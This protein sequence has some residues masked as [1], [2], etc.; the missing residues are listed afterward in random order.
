[1]NEFKIH[2]RFFAKL[3]QKAEKKKR[4]L[5]TKKEDKQNIQKE[6]AQGSPERPQ[7]KR[8]VPPPE[9][10]PAVQQP[11]AVEQLG[12]VA[13]ANGVSS[14]V[15]ETAPVTSI[16]GDVEKKASPSTDTLAK[17]K[18]KISNGV[19]DGVNNSSR[20]HTMGNGVENCYDGGI[21]LAQFLAETLQSQTAE[22]KQKL[23]RLEK[24]TEMDETEQEGKQKE[25]EEKVK[26][27]AEECERDKRRE[28]DL[29]KEREK[30]RHLEL[31][32]TVA[33]V[34]H[35]SEAK[36]HNKAHKDHEHHHIPASIS[37][38]L[39]SV[40]DFFFGK[41]KKDSHDHTEK[42]EK[43]VDHQPTS[44]QPDRP[45]P[46]THPIFRLQPGHEPDACKPAAQEILPM[47]MDKLK[48]PAVIVDTEKHS[49]SL[50]PLKP[51]E[52]E[53]GVLNADLPPAHKPPQSAAEPV[54]P[55]VQEADVEA[56]EVSVEAESGGPDEQ[57][58][59]SG[60]QPPTEVS[61]VISRRRG[62]PLES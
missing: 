1:M 52:C 59:E 24:P 2:Q 14:E 44:T 27:P 21:S 50:E 6:T 53:D 16:D 57:I 39:H 22:E 51:H 60:L 15:S 18:I 61:S 10:S 33:H 58:S 34:K 62:Q 11:E 36:H 30:E 17:K 42:E 49:V 31:S 7:R 4:E 12:A 55:S 5:E 3:K 29:S 56:M 45:L 37:S 13:E 26:S 23:S 20:G 8:S 9:E 54:G 32:H 25:K 41:S 46:P 38:M 48:E 35:G 43:E 47:K 19:D 28:R 40:K